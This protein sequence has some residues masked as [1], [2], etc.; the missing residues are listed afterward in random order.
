PDGV[1]LSRLLLIGGELVPQQ[2]IAVCREALGKAAT[3]LRAEDVGLRLPNEALDFEGL[4]APAGLASLAF[5]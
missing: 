5:R 2:I 4:A 1:R 3:I